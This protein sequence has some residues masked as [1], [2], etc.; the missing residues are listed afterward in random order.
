MWARCQRM[1]KEGC[2]CG[3]SMAACVTWN[4]SCLRPGRS[5]QLSHSAHCPSQTSQHA[6]SAP[7]SLSRTAGETRFDDL[8]ASVEKLPGRTLPTFT[9][10]SKP[11]VLISAILASFLSPS[12]FLQM[13][14]V[15]NEQGGIIGKSKDGTDGMNDS[16]VNDTLFSVGC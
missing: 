3:L 14:N 15:A 10:P 16:I 4:K 7:M 13:R 2:C 12:S 9:Q 8:A 5:S 6:T 1:E 11:A